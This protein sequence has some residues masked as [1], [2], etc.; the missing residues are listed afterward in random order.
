MP[1]PG[2]SVTKFFRRITPAGT[3]VTGKVLGD[4]TFVAWYLATGG[5]VTAYAHGS[6]ITEISSGYYA[7]TFSLPPVK[8]NWAVD[9]SPASGTDLLQFVSASGYVENNDLDLIAASVARPLV[10]ITGQ[11]TIGQ[12]TPVA[13]IHKRYRWLRFAFNDANGAAIDMTAGVNYTSYI[14]GIRGYPDQTLSPPKLDATDGL[15]TAGF[16][17]SIVGSLGYIDIK[18][19]MDA[20]I[21]GGLTEG[22]SALDQVEYRH[23]L[24][25]FDVTPAHERVSLVQSS[26]LLV[27]RRE[28]GVP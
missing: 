10:T 13:L 24:T 15:A 6:T 7:W 25:A 27:T 20:T 4:F 14:W 28:V 22:A 2:N 19:P 21:F 18:V 11:G 17:W 12:V 16:A 5:S 8:A 26:Q 3:A 1:I 23:E 9:I